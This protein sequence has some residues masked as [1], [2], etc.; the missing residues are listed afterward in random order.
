M[1]HT[2]RITIAAAAVLVAA[3]QA[4]GA[5][6][7]LVQNINLKLTVYTEGDTTTNSTTINT[8]V[9]KMNRTTQDIIQLL[10]EALTN[11]FSTSAKLQ[12]VSPLDDGESKIVVQDGTNQTDV[13]E[14]F[15]YDEESS[16]SVHGR[17]ITIG[18]GAVKGIE[19]SI[20]EFSLHDNGPLKLNAHFNVTGLATVKS[21]SIVRSGVVVGEAQQIGEP[22]RRRRL[23][24]RGRDALFHPA[25][26]TLG[27][28]EHTGRY[29][30]DFGES[31]GF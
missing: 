16:D 13:T 2:L 21:A 17:Q 11:S 8:P 29:A 28:R 31:L 22:G 7:N 20:I 27:G 15:S 12:L 18:T 23:Y 5:Q 19:Y 25:G 3:T 4:F 6:T 9:V 14:F 26:E 1:K 10:G 24:R 30:V